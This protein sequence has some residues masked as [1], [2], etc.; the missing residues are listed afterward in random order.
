MSKDFV[1]IDIEATAA[2]LIGHLEKARTTYALVFDGKKY[3]GLVTKKWLLTTR[4]DIDVMK[5]KN[6]IKKRNK[7][8]TPFYVP[9]LSAGTSLKE[10]VRLLATSD[11]RALPVVEHMAGEKN[12]KFE[13][14]IGVV[15]SMAVLD[16]IKQEYSKVPASKLAHSDVIS[17]YEDTEIGKVIKMMSARHI[18]HMPILNKEEKLVGV[19]SIID[20]L[21]KLLVW[22]R[23]RGRHI[24]KSGSQ[25]Q[26]KVTG[27]GTGEITSILL[28][29]ISNIVSAVA[30]VSCCSPNTPTSEVIKHMVKNNR[31]SMI[32]VDKSNKPVGILTVKDIL[33]DFVKGVKG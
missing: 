18:S 3:L 9:K 19:V 26:W 30:S 15:D 25:S 2:E 17:A 11:V 24:A 16:A 23:C 14:T 28:A 10:I 32:L 12:N 5:L 27:A 13:K 33:E 22:G 8:K 7:S 31:A 21:E 6:L 4:V 20:L 29:P 1:S